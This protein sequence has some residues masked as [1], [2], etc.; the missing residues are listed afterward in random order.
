MDIKVYLSYSCRGY[1]GIPSQFI[2]NLHKISAYYLKKNFKNVNLI[3]DSIS[4]KY[5]EDI[6]WD[7]ITTELDIV[8]EDYPSVWSLSKLYAYK[9][10]TNKNEPFIHV[11]NDV[12]LWKGLDENFLKSEVFAQSPENAEAYKYEPE[13]LY[14]NCPNLYVLE[15]K[16]LQ[17]AYNVGIFG[18]TNISFIKEYSEQSIKFVEDLI[19]R[20]FW[21]EYNG[22]TFHWAKAVTAEQWFLG[23]LAEHNNVKINALFPNH[24]WP[25]PEEAKAKYYTHMMSKKESQIEQEKINSLANRIVKID[26]T[27][28]NLGFDNE[29]NY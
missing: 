15:N 9:I 12:I 27:L 29:D 8:P 17:T 11:D 18:G 22:Y 19:N 1:K 7:S 4:K 23:A 13:K 24:G 5:F 20:K 2:I 10:I 26:N 28:Y 16:N 14:N 25:T 21:Q 3:T 6:P